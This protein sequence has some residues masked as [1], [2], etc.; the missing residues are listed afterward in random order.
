MDSYIP[1][2]MKESPPPP[3]LKENEEVLATID[4]IELDTQGKYG[5]QFRFDTTLDDHKKY[6]AKV[7]LKHYSTPGNRSFLGILCMNIESFTGVKYESLDA[8]MKALENDI[9]KVYLRC[10]G[11]RTIDDVTFP[12]FKVVVSKLPTKQAS[13]EDKITKE[14]NKENEIIARILA[15]KPQL[16]RPAVEKM[17]SAEVDK[18]IPREASIYVVAANLG[19]AI[20]Q[21]S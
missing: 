17:I 19:I 9:G 18:G 21:G 4:K 10:S 15:S 20:S 12:K 6:P 2:Y 14:P 11:H 13:L 8:A 7:W 16:T 5:D 3:E 1:A